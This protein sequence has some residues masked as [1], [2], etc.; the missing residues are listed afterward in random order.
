[1][2]A[3]KIYVASSWRNADQPMLVT[4]LRQQGHKVYDFRNPDGG[5][6]FQWAAID[7]AW[8]TW[9][10]TTYIQALKHPIAASGF[11]EDWKAMHWAD[12]CVL[13]L[14]CGR[15]AHLEAGWFVGQGRDVF[16]LI[17]VPQ[18]PELMYKMGAGVYC[19]LDDLLVAL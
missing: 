8:K 19:C 18:E 5:T 6:G 3:R 7:P 9:S 1:M 11:S 17:P 15:S 13:L 10:T 2:R 14:P 12:T 4:A 16:I